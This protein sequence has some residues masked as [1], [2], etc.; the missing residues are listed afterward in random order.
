MRALVVDE[1]AP[2]YAGCSVREFPTP[3]PGPGEVRLRV[4][5]AA[6]NFPDLMQTRGEYQHKPALPFIPGLELAGEIDRLGEGVTGFKIGDAVV[7]GARV[8]GMSEY[9]VAPAAALQAEA[10]APVASPRRPPT[11]WPTSPPMSPWSAAPRLQPGEWVLVHGAA[12]GVGLACVD[13][14]KVLGLRVIAG[15]ASDEKLAVIARRIRAGGHASTSP[16]AFA[17]G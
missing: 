17:S 13:L 3:E 7:G 8:G 10:G 2:D 4:R 14:A 12:G 6:V 5:A 1:L 15:S 9:A 11:A 16:A